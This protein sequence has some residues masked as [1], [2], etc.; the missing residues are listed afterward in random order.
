[1]GRI[2]FLMLALFAETERTC[3]TARA[4]HARS[5]AEAHN[6]HI[7]RPI[8]HPAGKIEY[9]RLLRGQGPRLRRDQ[10]QDEHL[11]GLA[12]P[13]PHAVAPATGQETG[14]Q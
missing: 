9:A 8:A 1:M 5:A 11:E 6:R 13:L 2:A 7:G 14:T 4:A 3:T 12:A 10:R